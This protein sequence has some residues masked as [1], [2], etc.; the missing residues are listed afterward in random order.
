MRRLPVDLEIISLWGGTREF[1]GLQI[2]LFPKWRLVAVIWLLPYWWVRKPAAFV[3]V[4]QRMAGS[5]I[6]S[7]LNFWETLLGLGFAICYA[8]SF[9]KPERRP[10]LIHAAWANVPA[11][12]AQLI[13]ALTGIPYSM[14]AH[15]YDVFR[16]GGD[17]FLTQKLQDSS[18][19]ITS[20]ES[21]LRRLKERGCDQGKTV[22]IKRG[23]DVLPPRKSCRSPRV[24]L[25]ILCVAR[26]V[27][28]KGYPEQLDIYG[29]LK[30]EGMEFQVRIVGS[31]PMKS[32][33]VRQI[34]EL[35][36]HSQI[37]LLGALPYAEIIEQ[38]AWADVLVFTG[39]VSS[40]GNR[41]GVPNVIPE[42]MAAGVPVV[43][44]PVAGVPEVIIDGENGIIIS[45][46]EPSKWSA[47]LQRLRDDDLYYEQLQVNGRRWVETHFDAH[48]N[49]NKAYQHFLAIAAPAQNN[50]PDL[51][52]STGA[53]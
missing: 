22:M 42:A 47:A 45:D 16:H 37:S 2:T 26:L 31:G 12:A 29:Q 15:A 28:K 32:K 6:P 3:Q 13:K 40:D 7:W 14:G 51:E 21:T 41:D 4:G 27:E 9:S 24:P 50:D 30:R 39:K 18:L 52:T 38:Y 53:A 46:F 48:V 5:P 25:R 8:A 44:S 49:T 36:L 23:L 35:T 17:W 34:N 43:S 11:T 10:D 19:V 1:E 20:S 33:M